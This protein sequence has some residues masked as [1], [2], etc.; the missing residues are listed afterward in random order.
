MSQNYKCCRKT[1][2][3]RRECQKEECSKKGAKNGGGGELSLALRNNRLSRNVI[4]RFS[5]FTLTTVHDV[6]KNEL[7]K[8][9]QNVELNHLVFQLT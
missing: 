2:K 7:D 5:H 6:R 4:T 3:T 9:E 8:K 1:G